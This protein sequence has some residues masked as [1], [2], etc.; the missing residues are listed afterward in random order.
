MRRKNLKAKK[1][2][3]MKQEAAVFCKV[4][5]VARRWG[6]TPYTVR[7]MI[8]EGRLRAVKLNRQTVVHQAEVRRVEQQGVGRG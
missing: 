7:A 6:V 3:E 4:P 2:L 8:R 1:E 5:A